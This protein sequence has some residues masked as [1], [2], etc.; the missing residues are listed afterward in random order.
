MTTSTT[1]PVQSDHVLTEVEVADSDSDYLFAEMQEG[2]R[3]YA[4]ALEHA[5]ATRRNGMRNPAF[6]T[7]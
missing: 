2:E 6:W 3:N 4:D 5:D 1:A 7:N